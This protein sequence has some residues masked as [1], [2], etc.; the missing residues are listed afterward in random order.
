MRRQL[1][2]LLIANYLLA[3]ILAGLLHNHGGHGDHSGCAGHCRGTHEGHGRH[4][5]HDQ[6]DD[7]APLADNE[8]CPACH[9]LAA[10]PMPVLL[11]IEVHDEAM[12]REPAVVVPAR[13]IP[14]VPSTKQIRA[15]PSIA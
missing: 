4:N 9:F 3:V 15:P 1:T 7:H 5:D 2:L 14:A 13:A 8:D 6:H 11:V 12:T 10:K